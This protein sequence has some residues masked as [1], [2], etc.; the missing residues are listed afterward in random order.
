MSNIQTTTDNTDIDLAP[1]ARVIGFLGLFVAHVEC[2]AG[3]QYGQQRPAAMQGEPD[4]VDAIMTD[5]EP[6]LQFMGS[7]AS[8]MLFVK[9]IDAAR[10]AYVE[11]M[12]AFGIEHQPGPDAPRNEPK[13]ELLP[14]GSLD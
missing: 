2:A 1:I 9:D 13:H 7:G 8:D 4:K 11:L 12:K 6:L 14:P 5:N 3:Y 10:K